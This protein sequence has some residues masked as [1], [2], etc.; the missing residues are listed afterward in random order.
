MFNGTLALVKR[1]LRVGSRSVVPH[2]LHFGLLVLTFMSLISAQDSSLGAPGLEVFGVMV[3]LN[4]CF[5]MLA[6]CGLFA[7]A[8]TEEK[9]E[10]TLSLLQMAGIN[11]LTL[12]LGKIVPRV[13]TAL[14]L[15]AVQIP[16]VVLAVTLGGVT[17]Q[18]VFAAYISLAA[19]VILI[20]GIALVASVFCRKTRTA[21]IL[22][23]LTMLF[24]LIGPS[25]LLSIMYEV[26]RTRGD[27]GLK[28]LLTKCQEANV[29]VRQTEILMST[30]SLKSGS[31]V[32]CFQ[33]VSNVLAG[34]F[35]FLFSWLIFPSCATDEKQGGSEIGTSIRRSFSALRP[36]R[37]WPMA[38]TWKDFHFN[39]GGYLGIILRLIAY[40][41]VVLFF[42]LL[43]QFGNWDTF[44]LD[45]SREELGGMM[46]IVAIIFAVLELVNI[47]GRL[48]RDEVRLKTWPSLVMLPNQ[49][50][51]RVIWPKLGGYLLA[52][53]PAAIYFG[54]GA[55]TAPD[56]LGEVLHGMFS[57]YTS[58]VMLSWVCV[59][60]GFFLHL[61]AF[62][63]LFLKWGAV[64]LAFGITYV[65]LTF[66]FATFGFLFFRVGG[67]GNLIT[68]FLI[69]IGIVATV[70]LQMA[71]ADRL[72]K[73]GA[74]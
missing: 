15:L 31:S 56:E 8:I 42:F 72:R 33:V 23:A 25:L 46:M 49:H 45:V 16:M 7:S 11:P 38:L 21:S 73:L 32:F 10:A 65:L 54:L 51:S 17:P 30:F 58:I 68:C 70:S 62:L 39:T 67:E 74:T 34:V 3:Y 13:L 37:A 6:G 18:Q 59:Q 48:F 14:L 29:F 47:S 41:A 40:P 2:L 5:I 20:A 64:P 71:I 26:H 50:V 57:D 43:F 19:F 28:W 36:G 35:A 27:S 9:E 12:L 61:A 69:L 63:S 60:F 4:L 55:I 24:L 1:S 53:I 22:T 52:L 66:C 44:F